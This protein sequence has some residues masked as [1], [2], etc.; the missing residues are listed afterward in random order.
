MR[1]VFL[2]NFVVTS[3]ICLVALAVL[4]ARRFFRVNFRFAL[5]MMCRLFLVIGSAVVLLVLAFT[6]IK[7]DAG[8][9]RLALVPY[10]LG[11]SPLLLCGILTM[12][13]PAPSCR[14]THASTNTAS[15]RIVLRTLENSSSTDEQK[16]IFREVLFPVAD[17]PPGEWMCSKE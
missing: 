6:L 16:R 15:R 14:T 11:A 12:M 5:T 7:Y 8:L 10:V 1:V 13:R 2:E 4:V 3:A 9:T 17:T